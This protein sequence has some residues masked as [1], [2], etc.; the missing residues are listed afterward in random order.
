MKIILAIILSSFFIGSSYAMGI[1]NDCIHCMYYQNYMGINPYQ[2]TGYEQIHQYYSPW[3]YRYSAPQYTNYNRP[4][5]WMQWGMN[6]HHFP[7]HQGGGVMGKPNVYVY[8]S[9][10]TEFEISI[11]F[12]EKSNLLSAIPSYQKVW[13]GKIVNNGI[14]HENAFYRYYYY[15]YGVDISK[16]QWESGKC[17]KDDELMG[18]LNNVLN[19]SGFRKKEIDDFNEYWSYKM[20]PGDSYCVYPQRNKELNKVARL[21][22]KPA[23]IIN[24]LSFFIVPQVEKDLNRKVS[25]FKKPSREWKAEKQN[26][27]QGIV[28]NEWGV[29]WLDQAQFETNNP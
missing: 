29:G 21:E 26:A 18:Y 3:W 15:D 14:L 1:G 23:A 12:S 17:V 22:T 6:G 7:T 27:N 25:S 28:I 20:P 10:N 4:A 8:G 19:Q 24:R 2:N 11:K 13:R 16:L 5:P 9:N